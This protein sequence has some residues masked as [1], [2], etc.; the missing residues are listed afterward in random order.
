MFQAT[1]YQLRMRSKSSGSQLD[2]QVFLVAKNV[3]LVM[4]LKRS[5]LLYHRNQIE[6]LD[7]KTVQLTMDL[8]LF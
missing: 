2:T 8:L 3:R 4:K 5:K 1:G 6:I 7:F